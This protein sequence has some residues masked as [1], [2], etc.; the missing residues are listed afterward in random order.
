MDKDNQTPRE[1]YPPKPDFLSDSFPWDFQPKWPVTHGERLAELNE[2][3]VHYEK[4]L[5]KDNIVA[6]KNWHAQFPPDKIVPNQVVWFLG[7]QKVEG[8]EIPQGEG[9]VWVEVGDVRLIPC[10]MAAHSSILGPLRGRFYG[11]TLLSYTVRE[12]T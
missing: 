12:R 7:G 3:S 8:S 4:T 5:Q 6:A 11:L 10:D 1:K 9:M 2:L